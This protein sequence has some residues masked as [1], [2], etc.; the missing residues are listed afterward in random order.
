M[1]LLLLI[2]KQPWGI[3]LLYYGMKLCD[4]FVFVWFEINRWTRFFEQ[5]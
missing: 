2:E 1:A 4:W 5:L 3:F